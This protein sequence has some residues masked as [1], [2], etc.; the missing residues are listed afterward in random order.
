MF[1]VDESILVILLL[2]LAE[3]IYRLLDG[4]VACVGLKQPINGRRPIVYPQ[5]EEDPAFVE[6]SNCWSAW[7]FKKKSSMKNASISEISSR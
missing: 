3:F 1:E 7:F 6:E 5:A 2:H 4:F